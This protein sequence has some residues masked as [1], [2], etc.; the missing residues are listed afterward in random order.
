MKNLKIVNAM[1]LAYSI[2]VILKNLNIFGTWRTALEYPEYEDRI[3]K[4][5]PESENFWQYNHNPES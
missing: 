5:T 4:R 2:K 1:V 3:R